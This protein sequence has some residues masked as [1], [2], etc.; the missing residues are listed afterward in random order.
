MR[1][2]AERI[3][4]GFHVHAL[5]VALGGRKRD[6]RTVESL[7]AGFV[8]VCTDDWEAL[9]Q[10]DPQPLRRRAMQAWI[11]RG[12]VAGVLAG[13]GLIVL[14]VMHESTTRQQIVFTL[15]GAAVAALASPQ[16]ALGRVADSVEALGKRSGS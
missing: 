16:D 14:L 3:A 2:R 15:W 6:E 13:A 11:R 5:A 9:T 8:A 10:A 1:D 12:A 7:V 4:A